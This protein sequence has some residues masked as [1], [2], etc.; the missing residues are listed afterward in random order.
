MVASRCESV[1]RLMSIE[2]DLDAFLAGEHLAFYAPC[3]L[4]DKRNR[5]NVVVP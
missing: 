4:T 5:V 2:T 1:W 3:F